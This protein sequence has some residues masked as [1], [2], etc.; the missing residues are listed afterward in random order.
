MVIKFIIIVIATLACSNISR[1]TRNEAI[2]ELNGAARERY[3]NVRFGKA[4]I[5]CIFGVAT[6][7]ALP[8]G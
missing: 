2:K 1:C 4:S 8:I 5:T 6:H 7:A 3:R